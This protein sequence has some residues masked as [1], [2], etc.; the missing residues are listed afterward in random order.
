MILSL[1]RAEPDRQ[2]LEGDG[3]DH[4]LAVAQSEMASYLGLAIETVCREMKNLKRMGSIQT[5]G[6]DRI[7]ILDHANLARLAAPDTAAS[8]NVD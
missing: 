4:R 7:A 1:P 8:V 3:I 5:A 2:K 6:R